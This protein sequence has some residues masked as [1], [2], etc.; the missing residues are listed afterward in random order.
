MGYFRQGALHERFLSTTTTGGTL[1]LTASSRPIQ[2]LTGTNTHTVQLPDATTLN[3]GSNNTGSRRFRIIN[4]STGTIIVTDGAG[5]P[6]GY[7]TRRS[8]AEF[9]LT[10]DASVAG[11]WRPIFVSASEA[12]ASLRANTPATAAVNITASQLTNGDGSATTVPPIRSIIPDVPDSTHDLQTGSTTGATFLGAAPPTT[13]VGYYRYAGYTLLAS[14]EIQVLWSPEAATIGALANP[15]T[16]LVR[17]GVPIGYLLLEATASNAFKTAGSATNVVESRVG[18]D[19]RLFRFGSG[20]G[21]GGSDGGDGIAEPMVGYQW[22]DAFSFDE[23]GTDT[24]VETGAGYTNASQSVTSDLYRM[25]CD[26]TK[27]VTTS[28]GTSLEISSAP[29]FTVAAGDIVYITSGSR[30]GQWRRIASVGTQTQ[31]TLDAAFSG[32]DATAGDTLMVSQAVWTKDLVNYGDP[33]ELNRARDFFSGDIESIGIDYFD[34]IAEEDAVPNYVSEAAVVVS[35]SNEGLVSDTGIPSSNTFAGIYTRPE[36]PDQIGDYDLA[37]NTDR[38]R[39]FLVFF[40]NP[41]NV[42]VTTAANILGYEASFYAEPESFNSGVLESAI[43]FSDNST[44]PVNC[45]VAQ[46][47]GFTVVTLGWSYAPDIRIG[48][49]VS[50]IDVYVD[51]KNIAR[52]ISG[53]ST[54]PSDLYWTEAS[55]LSGIRNKVVF[56]EDLSASPVEIKIVKRQGVYDASPE[57]TAK[58]AAI[59]GLIV[60]TADQLLEGIATYTSLQDAIDAAPS[61]AVITVLSGV[62][63]TE[64]ITLNKRL[65][66]MGMGGYDSYINGSFTLQSG[67]DFALV[68]GLRVSQF[69]FDAGSDGNMVT[70]SF[71]STDP[72]DNGTG[73]AYYGVN[74]T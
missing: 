2:V 22:L 59:H 57:T 65:S 8:S 35:A 18:T 3:G 30:A 71:W 44:T 6:L 32:G 66:I 63:I 26:K 25:L 5:T 1:T 38:E 7:L 16:V 29:S 42:S 43:C 62:S 70:D 4:R 51:G 53:A 31:Y 11:V 21:T 40:C 52:Y 23:V 41:E 36:A 24:R 15:G 56:S 14:G 54:P 45:T 49:P 64:N 34:S 12:P 28:S 55:D 20:G 60:G 10:N 73:N 50:N 9:L 69:V 27:T 58:L 61:G 72:T 37:A 33:A 13:T 68:R 19:P 67:C 17:S 39:L 47:F 48:E 74:I 46:E